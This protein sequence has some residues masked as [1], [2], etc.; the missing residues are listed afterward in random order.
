VQLAWRRY[1]TV[2]NAVPLP[3]QVAMVAVPVVAGVHW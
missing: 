2:S 3:L 1:T